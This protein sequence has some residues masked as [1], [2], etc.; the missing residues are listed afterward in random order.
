M[1]LG[2]GTD[3]AETGRIKRL[4][5]DASDGGRRFMER[6]YTEEEREYCNKFKKPWPSLAAR[7]AAKEAFFKA[8]PEP[9]QEGVGWK[10]LEV[11]SGK[12]GRPGLVA[13]G[14]AAE[15]VKSLNARLHISL[16]HTDEYA[17]AFVILETCE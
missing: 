11:V 14:R 6:V 15:A 8:L 13:H 10:D 3:L 2:V 5:E 4:I 12:D 7:F 16:T 17:A 1:I 9:W